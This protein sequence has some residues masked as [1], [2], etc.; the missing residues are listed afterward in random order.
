[1]NQLDIPPISFARYVDLVKRRR[2]QVIPMSLVGLLVGA[3]VAFFIPRYFIAHTTI[4]YKGGALDHSSRTSRDPLYAKVTNALLTIKHTIPA[5]LEKLNLIGTNPDAVDR[6]EAI[7]R[8]E[9][10]VDVR[11]SMPSPDGYV[12]IDV[13]VRDL[14]G[15]RAALL[16]NTLRLLW[17]EDIMRTLEREAHDALTRAA[18]AVS[19]A[20]RAIDT[21]IDEIGA[22]Q[23]EHRVDATV[24]PNAWIAS[25]QKT[26]SERVR[27]A[28]DRINTLQIEISALDREADA[29][30]DRLSDGSV[31][32]VLPGNQVTRAVDKE[33][34]IRIDELRKLLE[35]ER[36]VKD[37]RHAG[38]PAHRAAVKN[39]EVIEKELTQMLGG[40]VDESSPGLNLV[41]NP[42]HA[43]LKEQHR[44]LEGQLADRRA[45]LAQ[46]KLRRE[47]DTKEGQRV[48]L[49]MTGYLRLQKDKAALELRH[50]EAIRVETEQRESYNRTRT[51][52]PFEQVPAVVPPAPTEPG[53]MLV[54]LAG[55]IVGLAAAIGLVLL[56]D[57]IRSTFKT[58]D[59]VGYALGVPVLGMMA[60]LETAEE[61]SR[62]VRHRRRVSLVAAT[63]VVLM[64]SVVTVYYVNPTSLPPFVL[65]ALDRVLGV[66]KA[67]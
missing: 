62:T 7:A 20:S 50:A 63:F 28:E 67:K 49:A 27:T 45:A 66:D 23:R 55:S 58:V 4:T 51:G 47:E 9:N 38:S 36:Y 17:I 21:K 31:K 35:R 65:Q 12:N 2:W 34:Q 43:V 42:E 11:S 64:L 8:M 29:I 61:R 13:E 37:S 60:H 14:D 44:K 54:A 26:L 22:Y 33:T 6:F 24:D 18:S 59:D 25:E 10:R 40:T 39:I 30:A 52:E 15:E 41:P 57:F 48:T 19:D 1:M 56:L 5:A 53:F 46:A 32:P 16:A 3:I